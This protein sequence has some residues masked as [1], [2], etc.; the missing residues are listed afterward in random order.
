MSAFVDFFQ[1]LAGPS[2][3]IYVPSLGHLELHVTSTKTIPHYARFLQQ[4]RGHFY[5]RGGW[6]WGRPYSGRPRAPAA[7]PP[8]QMTL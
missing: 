5:Y 6:G 4:E 3:N 7:Q 8:L 1:L 2:H